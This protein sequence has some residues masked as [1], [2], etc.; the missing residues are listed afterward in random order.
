[1]KITAKPGDLTEGLFGQVFLWIF[2]ILPWLQ[3]N[4]HTT[5]SWSICSTLYGTPPY[6]EI[7]PGLL[8]PVSSQLSAHERT[9]TLF[10]LR[11][12]A[13]SILGGDFRYAHDLWHSYFRIPQK[14]LEKADCIAL[15]DST[16]G[17]HYRGTDKN[18]ADWDTNPVSQDDFL[19]LVEDFVS[20]RQKIVCLFIATDE[21]SFI[22]TAKMRFPYLTIVNISP[23][24]FHK[25]GNFSETKGSNALL[26][27][28]LLSRCNYVL[29]GCS[30][31][32]AFAKVLNPSLEIYRVAASKMFGDFPYFPTAYISRMSS[33]NLE[34]RKILDRLFTDDWYNNPGARETFGAPFGARARGPVPYG[35]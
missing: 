2:E 27:C 11:C 25:N 6:C 16:L 20:T 28:V 15:P 10:E 30:A 33:N 31:L 3:Q 35:C 1:M 34:C 9:V 7:I 26:D 18:T 23:G 19:T 17:V 29:Q 21:P 24:E 22:L 32:S 14:I 4:G 12:H 8:E 5:P 13:C